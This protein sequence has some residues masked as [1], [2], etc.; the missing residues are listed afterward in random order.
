METFLNHI[1]A[2]KNANSIYSRFPVVCFSNF[3]LPTSKKRTTF[4]QIEISDSSSR[5][6]QLLPHI[7]SSGN[8]NFSKLCEICYIQHNLSCKVA[9]HSSKGKLFM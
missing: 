9:R 2:Q 4:S 5:I 6:W 3:S 8:S 7:G 1:T